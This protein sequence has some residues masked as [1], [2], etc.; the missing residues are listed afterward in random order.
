MNNFSIQF[1]E[2]LANIELV[3]QTKKETEHSKE[4]KSPEITEESD[5]KNK[6]TEIKGVEDNF[7]LSI[8]IN[9]DEFTNKLIVTT[10]IVIYI[11][12]HLL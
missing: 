2:K 8:G 7:N 10:I 6:I 3:R 4:G 1:Q 5:D 9:N 11:T 12:L